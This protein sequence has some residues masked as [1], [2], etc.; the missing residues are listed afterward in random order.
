MKGDEAKL[1]LGFA[2]NSRPSPSQVKAAYKR[3]VWECHPDLFPARHKKPLA[4]SNFKLISEAHTFLLSGG[5]GEYLSSATYS[6]VVKTGVP[7]AQGGSYRNHALIQ[8]PF[9]F[10]VLGTVALGG[11]NASRAY[12]K[13]KEAYPSHNPFLP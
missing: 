9:L 5:N 7:R 13:Q 6:R 11:F 8:M 1:L 10:L 4:E 3:K 2:P 12:K